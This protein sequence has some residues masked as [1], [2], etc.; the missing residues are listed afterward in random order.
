MAAFQWQ[1][2]VS[3]PACLYLLNADVACPELSNYVAAFQWQACVSVPA[4]LC[5]LNADVA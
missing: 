1:A 2:C 4:C 3:V 5:L